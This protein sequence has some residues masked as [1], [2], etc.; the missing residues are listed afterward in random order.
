LS[1]WVIS[2]SRRPTRTPTLASLVI[3]AHRRSSSHPSD[4]HQRLGGSRPTWSSAQAG[5]R[6]CLPHSGDGAHHRR[7]ESLHKNP[8]EAC[9]N[10][11]RCPIGESIAQASA[12]ARRHDSC[13]QKASRSSKA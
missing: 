10:T 9:R 13:P 8:L 11:V 3:A 1:G 5:G 2:I 6:R 7:L 12:V 4:I